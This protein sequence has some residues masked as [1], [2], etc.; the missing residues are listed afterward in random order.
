MKKVF[1]TSSDVIHLFAQQEQE[2]ARCHN[3]FYNKNK[4]Y[5]Y[6]HHYL[7][8][9]FLDK[10]TILIN[11]EGAS[12]T[13]NK[14]IHELT[15]ATRQYTQF[16]KSKVDLEKV[17]YQIEALQKLLSKAIKPEKYIIQIN[18]LWESM[19][20]YFVYKKLKIKSHATYK[21]IKKIW[22]GIQSEGYFEKLKEQA[23]KDNVAKKKKDAKL[24]KEALVKFNNFEIRTF[25]IGDEDYLRF[26]G[27]VVETSQ[28]VAIQQADA[29]KLFL[30][31]KAGDDIVGYKIR[32]YTVNS[33]GNT[34]TIGCH[35]INM[36]SVH[37]IG[38]QL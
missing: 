17:H 16:F 13:T 4:I 31:I 36:E 8:G 29:K 25:R 9:E 22:K 19:N 27:D 38:K 1:N 33:I 7:L 5:S 18:A 37:L 10:D 21:K 32:G 3:V 23:K 26:N 24:L 11:D 28:G 34:L 14:H 35:R 12:V 30:A 20:E 6:G 15:W 2:E